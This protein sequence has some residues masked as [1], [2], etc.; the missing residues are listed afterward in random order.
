[1][2]VF[3][4]HA[5]FT[6]TVLARSLYR[7]VAQAGMMPFDHAQLSGRLHFAYT[8][9][10]DLADLVT[11]Y[12]KAGRP[13]P[14]QELSDPGLHS[15]LTD[16]ISQQDVVVI[17]WSEEYSGKFW[18]QREWR[19]SL[20]MGVRLVIVSMDS[21]P[22]DPELQQAVNA[23]RT[24]LL[25]LQTT[26][27]PEALCEALHCVMAQAC[28][29]EPER[30][31]DPHLRCSFLRVEHPVLGEYHI[32]ESCWTLAQMALATGNR[33]LARATPDA[34]AGNIAWAAADSLCHSMSQ[35]SPVYRYRL[36][37]ESEW[38]FAARAGG[39]CA[40]HSQTRH[41][42]ANPETV[43]SIVNA[44]GLKYKPQ[45]L[46]WT[47][48]P[49]EWREYNGWIQPLEITKYYGPRRA[50]VV[51]NLMYGPGD[52][53]Y[54]ILYDNDTERSDLGFRLVR[55]TRKDCNLDQVLPNRH[56]ELA[57]RL[58]SLSAGNRAEFEKALDENMEMRQINR[59]FRTYLEQHAVE[60]SW[61]MA[62]SL[63]VEILSRMHIPPIS[64]PHYLQEYFRARVKACVTEREPLVAF[65][66]LLDFLESVDLLGRE[67]AEVVH[68]DLRGDE[69]RDAF[70]S[71]T[72]DRLPARDR[73]SC[74]RLLW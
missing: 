3:I 20:A 35:R 40:S 24:P 11:A 66:R 12:R 18:T 67:F 44:W 47:S 63:L 31:Q 61:D 46:E 10:S 60:G 73:E 64:L 6:D 45:G 53:Y 56:R 42:A 37:T 28:V 49:G 25:D 16:A 62:E 68:F 2:R 36:P 9:G 72:L 74:E 1:M 32:A 7:I 58:L 54:P 15:I 50:H 57:R 29:S 26:F 17:L 27:S 23:G 14:S 39:R 70:L 38:D 55:T 5:Y 65:D 43:E 48:T 59:F 8:G 52:G 19:T 33:D 22:L 41:Q 71:R 51:K 13:G 69:S 4:S 34:M 30:A 21:F